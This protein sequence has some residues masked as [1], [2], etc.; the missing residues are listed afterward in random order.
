M[1]QVCILRASA[2]LALF[3]QSLSLMATVN[4]LSIDNIPSVAFECA[5]NSNAVLRLVVQ[6]SGSGDT[7]QSLIVSNSGPFGASNDASEPSEIR[8]SG[9]KLWFAANTST[10]LQDMTFI[11]SMSVSVGFPRTW[12]IT[13]LSQ[14]IMNGNVLVVTFDSQDAIAG[15]RAVQFRIPAGGAVFSGGN[16][17][18]L[19][20]SNT[21]YQMLYAN[22][23]AYDFQSS[24]L[25]DIVPLIDLG[26]TN[27]PLA[28]WRMEN[29]PNTDHDNDAGCYI[30]NFTVYFEDSF[31]PVNPSAILDAIQVVNPNDFSVSMGVTA[32]NNP[33][34][35]GDITYISS[36]ENLKGP[37]SL[38][39]NLT[40][41]PI[42][43]EYGAYFQPG[44]PADI[45]ILANIKPSVSI[46]N[47][48]MRILGAGDYECISSITGNP[49]TAFAEPSFPL[50]TSLVPVQAPATILNTTF[51]A[52]PS[53][54]E[55]TKGAQG[56]TVLRIIYQNPGTANTGNIEIKTIH[57]NLLDADDQPIVPNLLLSRVRVS[58]GVNTYCDKTT[59]PSS[60]NTIAVTLTFPINV[61][62]SQPITTYV[63]VDVRSDALPT[64]VKFTLANL[65]DP[66]LWRAVQAGTTIIVQ[67]NGNTP[68]ATSAVPIVTSL[69]ATHR[70][71]L[72]AT[73]YQGQV[74]FPIFEL[75]F[76][77]PGATT[78]GDVVLHSI[79][80]QP[81]DA[82]GNALNPTGLLSNAQWSNDSVLP[83]QTYSSTLDTFTLNF[84]QGI[85]LAPSTSITLTLSADLTSSTSASSVRFSIRDAIA[86]NANQP[87]NPG[88]T[89][90]I[91]P[92]P[93][94]AYPM[95]TTPAPILGSAPEQSF[96]NYPN[97]FLAG[98]EMTTLSYYL[99]ASSKV[100]LT[101][102]TLTGVPVREMLSDVDQT[103]GSQSVMWDGHNGK[104]NKVLT[105]V[106]VAV[107]KIDSAGTVT[108]VKRL[109]GVKK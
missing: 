72:P 99:T 87:S 24:L 92:G 41:D 100:S 47:L 14:P 2:I 26:K 35:N 18:A 37:G 90:S 3:F 9:V 65:T 96:T 11:G 51:S 81:Q 105:G 49:V 68:F 75:I 8:A 31:G 30:P 44:L 40:M 38:L 19:S 27:I 101:I 60:G 29:N 1:T 84:S 50:F 15:M 63:R 67:S 61:G 34:I 16:Q 56:V 95:V 43:Y 77:H 83:P 28:T 45:R 89:V 55:I 54:T 58:D 104:G 108:K 70:S 25:T 74:G 20:L 106:Y 42:N 4:N 86:F 36:N 59:I 109:L 12:S 69:Q 6:D 21:D 57:F 46:N 88:R 17:P 103:A 32:F 5:T 23:P 52:I 62:P 85:T 79:N 97:P 93:N 10:L 13:G 102:Y 66:S 39:L 71:L 53:L 98:S 48:R 33:Y 73:L 76:R 82:T 94:D 107:L 91:Q 22:R 78:V 64:D 7:L 80:I